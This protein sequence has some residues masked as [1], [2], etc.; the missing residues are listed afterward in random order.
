MIFSSFASSFA[1][2]NLE[3]NL[4]GLNPALRISSESVNEWTAHVLPFKFSFTSL[5][6]RKISAKRSSFKR[7]DEITYEI[8]NK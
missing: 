6:I 7:L 3:L 8:N 4:K 5:S 1:Y 2:S